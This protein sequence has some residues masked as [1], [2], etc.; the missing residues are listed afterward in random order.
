MQETN[1]QNINLF[2]NLVGSLETTRNLLNFKDLN[3]VQ[4]SMETFGC[5]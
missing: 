3:I 2:S 4:I 1:I 5:N